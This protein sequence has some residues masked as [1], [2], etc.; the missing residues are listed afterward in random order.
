MY[1]M[2]G[3]ERSCEAS[4]R[5]T[6]RFTADSAG[7]TTAT[8]PAC[9]GLGAATGTA[10]TAHFLSPDSYIGKAIAVAPPN[11]ALA[12]ETAAMAEA[13]PCHHHNLS[14]ISSSQVS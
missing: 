2:C 9:G 6:E 10:S 7:G 8:S 14:A 4:A 5:R 11:P 3:T 12:C 1:S 13:A